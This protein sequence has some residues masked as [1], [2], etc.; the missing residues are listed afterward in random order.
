MFFLKEDVFKIEAEDVGPLYKI[1]LGHNNK[2]ANSGW[3]CKDV[4]IQRHALKGSKRMKTGDYFVFCSLF[5]SF[6]NS[7]KKIYN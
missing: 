2:G 3:Y 4:V 1:R 6:D 7:I 5:Y